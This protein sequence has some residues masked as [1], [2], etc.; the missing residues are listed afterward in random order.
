MGHGT[1]GDERDVE[2]GNSLSGGG[3][4]LCN[5][6]R[7]YLLASGGSAQQELDPQGNF[8]RTDLGEKNPFAGHTDSDGGQDLRGDRRRE[9]GEPRHRGSL[10]EEP[11]L[12]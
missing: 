7:D 4:L 11:V 10:C 1:E 12:A 6:H 3:C 2:R 8:Q 5:D 9:R